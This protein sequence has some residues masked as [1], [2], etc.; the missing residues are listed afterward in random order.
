MFEFLIWFRLPFNINSRHYGEDGRDV[1]RETRQ[2]PA[3]S[4]VGGG[5]E[6]HGQGPIYS[7]TC[8]FRSN[9]GLDEGNTCFLLVVNG[10][11]TDECNALNFVVV[12]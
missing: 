12:V 5:G 3:G 2:Q 4:R 9:E 8:R 10:M 11:T 7:H 1:G 6:H